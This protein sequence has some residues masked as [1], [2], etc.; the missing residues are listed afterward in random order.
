[1]SEPVTSKQQSKAKK[2]WYKRV[3][4]WVIVVIVLLAIGGGASGDKGTNTGAS[5]PKVSNADT[6]TPAAPE[7]AKEKLTISNSVFQDKSYGLYQVDGE[8]TNH[9]NVKHSATIKATFY[10]ANGK[11]MG[12]AS[13]AVNDIE[14]GQTKTFTLVGTDKVAGYTSMKVE[15]DTLL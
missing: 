7:S 9:D 8:A 15:V 13:G 3:W 4:V 14:P 1:M 5:K 11:I 12:T 10:D 2:P 6:S